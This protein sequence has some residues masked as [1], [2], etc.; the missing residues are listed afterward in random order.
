MAVKR[1]TI[2]A[3]VAQFTSLMIAESTVVMDVSTVFSVAGLLYLLSAGAAVVHVLLNKHNVSAAFS[4]IGVIVL[5]PFFGVVLYWLFG[6]NRIRRRAQAEM[7]GRN[8]GSIRTNA[9]DIVDPAAAYSNL[10]EPQKQLFRTGLSIHDSPYLDGNSIDALMNGTEAFPKMLAAIV[11]AKKSIVLSSYI[12]EYDIVGKQFVIALGDAHNRGVSV[13]VS[14]D[15]L[16]VGYGFSFVKADRALRKLGVPTA[17]FL[18]TFSPSG[19]RF[20]NLRNHRKILSV[21][22]EQAFVG[23][24]NIRAGNLLDGKSPHQAQDVHFSIRGPTIDQINRVFEDDWLFATGESISL[25]VWQGAG[26]PGVTCRVLLDGPDDNYQKLELSIIAAINSARRH[27]SIATPYFLPGLPVIHALHLAV[28][29]GVDVR[30]LI[31][32]KNN[33]FF[34]DWAMSANESTILNAGI[35]LYRG[36]PPFD[37]S[38]LFVVDS[39]WSLIGSSNWDARSLELNFEINVECYSEAFAHK[40]ENILQEKIAGA[41]MS[42]NTER[43]LLIGLRNN[44]CRLFT[45]YL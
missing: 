18:P 28:L 45:P 2:V 16:G 22:G 42:T 33:L 25:P 21:D 44:F 15:G 37:H 1:C 5:S 30:V 35:K 6:I 38:K 10:A 13:F 11:G 36:R 24:M 23:G 19:T 26:K 34:V 41:K 14:I 43:S 8:E 29:R 20:I 12:F 40:L 4:W 7:R 32:D 31:P 17:R 27:I 9:A 39:C 3:R